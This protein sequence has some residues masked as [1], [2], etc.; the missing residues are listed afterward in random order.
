[1]SSQCNKAEEK[2]FYETGKKIKGNLYLKNGFR[3]D[4]FHRRNKTIR[5]N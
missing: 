4:T 1:M 2:H 5:G 3:C